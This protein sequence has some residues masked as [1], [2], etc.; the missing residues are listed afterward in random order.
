[1]HHGPPRSRVSRTAR[2]SLAALLAGGGLFTLTSAA[3]HAA[4][5]RGSISGVVRECGPDPAWGRTAPTP[6][7]VVLVHGGYTV[8]SESIT[9]A[10]A[11]PWSGTFTFTVPPG[12]SQV[13]SSYRGAVRTVK[14][15]SGVRSQVS[16]GMVAC[17]E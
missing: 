10:S 13:V 3:A 4:P 1:M 7:M 9:F 16:F 14:V 5:S 17:P 12:T 6:A 11:A 8:N 15:R 2:S